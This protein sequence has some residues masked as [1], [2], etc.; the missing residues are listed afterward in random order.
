M[1]ET[2]YTWTKDA[3]LRFIQEICCNDG[4][5]YCRQNCESRIILPNHG[6]Y[7]IELSLALFNC[8]ENKVCVDAQLV[9]GSSSICN[10]T[11][12]K[13]ADQHHVLLTHA[14]LWETPPARGDSFLTIRL[15]SPEHVSVC[16]GTL[17]IK[18]IK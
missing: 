14:F 6:R 9:H 16:Q 12:C 15:L 3:T 7:E 10:E 1:A 2:Q 18:R 5:R 11:I 8:D 4:V 17:R 13:Q